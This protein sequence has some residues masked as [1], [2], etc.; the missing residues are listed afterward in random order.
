MERGSF[1]EKLGFDPLRIL[2][3]TNLFPP[4]VSGGYEIEAKQISDMLSAWGHEMV[5]LTSDYQSQGVQEDVSYPVLRQLRLL[6]PF[7]QPVL[8][9][10]RWDRLLTYGHNYKTTRRVLQEIHPEIIFHWSPL[11]IGL[12]PARAAQAAGLPV[13]WRLGDLGLASFV[14]RPVAFDPLGLCRWIVDAAILS[15]CTL[16]GLP[17]NFVSCITRATKEELIARGVPVEAAEVN[18]KGIPMEKFPLKQAVGELSNPIRILFVGRLHPEKG[19]PTLIEATHQVAGRLSIPVSLTIAGTGADDYVRQLRA[20]AESGAAK[21]SFLGYID[22]DSIGSV[23]RSHDLYVLP[24]LI[25]EGF[26]STLQEA[27]ASGLPSISTSHGG[28][29]ELLIHE[30]NSLLFKAGDAEELAAQLMRLIEDRE[31]RRHIARG[32][33]QLAESM[34]SLEAYGRRTESFLKTVSR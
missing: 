8:S 14:A 32:G 11:R 7:D 13:A 21:V 5:I 15:K 22:Y 2:L 3:I 1:C 26:A 31:L 27:L 33:R 34:Y 23:Y 29:A 30:Q 17:L 20:Q 25:A 28:Q 6:C 18:Y 24:S 4:V 10:R 19:V 12:G 16:A 9:P